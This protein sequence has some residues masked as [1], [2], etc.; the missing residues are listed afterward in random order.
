MP[1]TPI[2]RAFKA[3]GRSRPKAA[4]A[5]PHNPRISTQSTMEPSWFPQ[6][7]EIL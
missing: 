7:P 4:T 1:S 2:T 6:A 5:A 3:V